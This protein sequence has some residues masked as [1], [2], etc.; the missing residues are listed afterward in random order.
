MGGG[1]DTRKNLGQIIYTPVLSIS[2]N[3][4]YDLEQIPYSSFCTSI[5][6]SITYG[7]LFDKYYSV[8]SEIKHA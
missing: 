1:R 6:S 7:L 8:D 4:A 5:Y 2:D 3:S